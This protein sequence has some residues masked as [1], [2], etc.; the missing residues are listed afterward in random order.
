MTAQKRYFNKLKR[1]PIKNLQKYYDKARVTCA[2]V[3]DEELM[4]I[5]AT[6]TLQK[7][8]PYGIQVR[9]CFFHR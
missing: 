3:T 6:E 9:C 4:F 5:T 7:Q 8:A 1:K 2:N